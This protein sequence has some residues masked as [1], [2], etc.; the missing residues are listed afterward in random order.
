MKFFLLHYL[1]CFALCA[2]LYSINITPQ[3][4]SFYIIIG[5]MVIND[6]L[7]SLEEREKYEKN[8]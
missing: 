4:L 6:I 5:A 7:S 2:H 1:L 3:G 8:V